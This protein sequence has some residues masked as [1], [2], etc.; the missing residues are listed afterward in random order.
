MDYEYELWKT[1]TGLGI[2]S[3][4]ARRPGLYYINP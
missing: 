4:L 2:R 3:F 1:R